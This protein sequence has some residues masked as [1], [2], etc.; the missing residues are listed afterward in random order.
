MGAVPRTPFMRAAV[1]SIAAPQNVTVVESTRV[2]YPA[3]SRRSEGHLLCRVVAA[4]VNPV[5]AKCV[6]A[7]KLP[8]RCVSLARRG[9][10]GCVVGF[11]FSGVVVEAAGT[12]TYKVGDEVYGCMPPF[13]GTYC[14]YV[15]APVSQVSNKPSSISHEEAAALPIPIVT[16]IQAYRAHGCTEA[17]KRILILGASGGVGTIA[18]QVAK[19]YGCEVTAVCSARNADFVTSLG[20]DHVIRYDDPQEDAVKVL[21][22][23]ASN[24]AGRFDMVFDTVSS[25][26]GRDNDRL[27]MHRLTAKPSVLRESAKH[28]YVTIGGPT[29][30]WVRSITK[31]FLG[32][33]LFSSAHDHHWI[34]FPGC[35]SDL[36]EA[37]RLVD[38][39]SVRPHVA[40]V[41]PFTSEGVQHAFA[42]MHSRRQRGKVVVKVADP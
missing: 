20:A 13:K 7:D 37:A 18:T 8:A 26:E 22:D 36:K 15:R 38:T 32:V 11:D 35:A 33:N 6:I 4:G 24:E 2:L 9:V 41:V 3:V 12:S 16:T 40:E 17:G 25:H 1:Y 34:R 23:G 14:E 30:Y 19:A 10:E 28:A 31:R 29:S 21:R 39:K 42:Q 27:Y 5:D